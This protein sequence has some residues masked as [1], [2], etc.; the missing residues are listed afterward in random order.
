MKSV[1]ERIQKAR[2]AAGLKQRE[3]AA[4]VGVSR[5]TI[6]LWEHDNIHSM[7][8]DRLF[9][10]ARRLKCDPDWILTGRGGDQEDH[11]PDDE[12]VSMVA[13]LYHRLDR[14]SRQAILL[15][16]RGLHPSE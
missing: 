15:I 4:A 6:S 8:S 11:G 7:R 1:G 10:L 14:S 13:T 5:S 2:N 9:K 12:E 16:L 3:L